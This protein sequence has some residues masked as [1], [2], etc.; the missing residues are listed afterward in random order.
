MKQKGNQPDAFQDQIRVPGTS[1]MLPLVKRAEKLRR[2]LERG[3][4]RDLSR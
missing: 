4:K 3:D 1:Q 2:V